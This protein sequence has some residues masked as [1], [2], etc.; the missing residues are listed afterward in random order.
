MPNPLLY[1]FPDPPRI[2]LGRF[3]FVILLFRPRSRTAIGDLFFSQLSELPDD[4]RELT[5]SPAAVSATCV[6]AISAQAA[7]RS[8]RQIGAS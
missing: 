5:E 3:F 8:T 4:F 6:T 2:A 1:P 7:K